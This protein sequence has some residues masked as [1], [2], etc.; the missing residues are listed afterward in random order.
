MSTQKYNT[1]RFLA[2]QIKVKER[3]II[4][5]KA[6]KRKGKERVKKERKKV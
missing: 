3:R 1:T 2:L 6:S 5:K 4:L